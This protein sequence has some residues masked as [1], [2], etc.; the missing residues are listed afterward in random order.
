MV[1]WLYKLLSKVLTNRFKKVVPSF[2]G[3][4][5]AAFLGGRQILDGILIANKVIDSW[6][7]SGKQGLILK[8]DFEK[9]YD[10]VNWN[11]LFTMLRKFGCGRRWISWIK[12]CI[13]TASLS[14]LI[15]GSPTTE[16]SME[17]GLRQG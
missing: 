2:V 15:N 3:D 6:K 11:Y 13:T 1:G 5:Q 12:A 4:T 8:L 9:A 7:K 14:V 17:K 16:F 10:S